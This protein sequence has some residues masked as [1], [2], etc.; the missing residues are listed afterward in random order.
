MKKRLIVLFL[1]SI[2]NGSFAQSKDESAVVK[3]VET[4][5]KAMIDADKIT[6]ENSVADDL[7]YGHS[8]NKIEDKAEFVR[9]IVSGESD[10]VTIDLTDQTIKIVGNNAIVRHKLMG[11]TNN[12]GQA[13]T[14][15]LSV[16]LVWQKQKG[17]W[18][19]LARQ[20]VK[21]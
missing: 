10:F 3:A 18:K 11:T 19:L 13:G 14:A 16:L 1:F 8:N 5:R 9:A 7:S 12:N 20:A 4:L 21:I 6:L 2:V 15:K 17:Q